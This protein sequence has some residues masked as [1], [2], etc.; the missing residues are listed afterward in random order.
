MNAGMITVGENYSRIT[1]FVRETALG[2]GRDPEGIR[3]VAVSKTVSA[4]VV[5]EAIDGGIRLFGENRI[6]EAK[7]KIPELKGDF[8]FHLVGHL[9]SNKAR[10]AVRLFDVIHSIDKIGTAE[11]VDEE[12]RRAGKVQKVLAQVNT[13]GEESKAG[14]TP[15]GALD[16][17]RAVQGLRN[18]EL[19]GLMTIG[20][21]TDDESAVRASFAMLREL[22][23]KINGGLGTHMKELS[24]GMSSD[25]RIAVEEG[26][27][28]VRIG[29]AIF[30]S[31]N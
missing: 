23:E 20:P 1:G 7:A 6:Q 25:Y 16:L 26:A 17:C 21:L 29:T 28:M 12:A 14:V 19:L 5:Q 3:V 22:L 13:S 11:K 27:T 30:G 15:D 24:M 4:S 31:R 18:I 8:A 9:Q 2:A 10:D